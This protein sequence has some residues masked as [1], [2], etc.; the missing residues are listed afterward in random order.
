MYARPEDR[1][2]WVAKLWDL[3]AKIKRRGS[4]GAGE[5]V[6][7]P[8]FVVCVHLVTHQEGFLQQQVFSP[9]PL[10]GTLKDHTYVF[11][12]VTDSHGKPT[13][14]A[15]GAELPG[16]DLISWPHTGKAFCFCFKKK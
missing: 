12:E 11:S 5:S 13:E 6:L 15:G 2:L 10:V 7:R 3:A 8:H 16:G 4:R 9:P 14:T 1:P